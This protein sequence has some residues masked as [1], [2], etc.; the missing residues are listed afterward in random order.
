VLPTNEVL[1]KAEKLAADELEARELPPVAVTIG[2]SRTVPSH[3]LRDDF[4]ARL[5]KFASPFKRY[6]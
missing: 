1:A 5:L 6:S 4:M 2:K 3:K